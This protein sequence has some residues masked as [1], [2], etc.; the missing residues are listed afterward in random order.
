MKKYYYLCLGLVLLLSA[1]REPEIPFASKEVPLAELLL[2][3]L[4]VQ[5]DPFGRSPLSA[6]LSFETKQQCKLSLSIL[7]AATLSQ[8]FAKSKEYQIPILGLYPAKE[9][10]IVL[11]I[12]AENGWYAQDTLR[13]QTEVLLDLLPEIQIVSLQAERME[14]GFHFS[15]FN[16]PVER[17]IREKGIFRL[18]EALQYL[19]DYQLV[20]VGEGADLALFEDQIL[21]AGLA[22][23]VS[24][25]GFLPQSCLRKAFAQAS[26]LVLPSEYREVFGIVGIEA[27]AMGLPC[28]AS[29]IGGIAEW[30]KG[31]TTGLLVKSG[32]TQALIRNIQFLH[33]QP[34]LYQRIQKKGLQHQ[35]EYFSAEAVLPRLEQ[36]Y[37]ATFIKKAGYQAYERW[38]KQHLRVPHGYRPAGNSPIGYRSEHRHPHSIGQDGYYTS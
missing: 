21:E 37:Q 5:K 6:L 26:C 7:G 25:L 38:Q 34:N 30:C 20:C 10:K 31:G 17:M 15:N 24:T 27:Q 11:D 3:E 33:S 18:L 28:I 16:R 32:D 2:G 29:D 9:N 23:R 1:C 4:K 14:A 35:K 8:N 19:E 13:I 12:V 22:E 36:L